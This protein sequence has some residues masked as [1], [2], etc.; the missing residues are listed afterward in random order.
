MEPALKVTLKSVVRLIETART[1]L[2][3][4]SNTT[5]DDKR[6][7]FIFGADQNLKIAADRVDNV[8]VFFEKQIKE[9]EEEVR[10]VDNLEARQ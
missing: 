5:D 4:A 10:Y 6:F 1:N 9:L 7:E 8:I 3:E 2:T